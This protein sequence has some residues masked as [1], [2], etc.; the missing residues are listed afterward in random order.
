MM[1]IIDS[2]ILFSALIK[3]S[4]TRKLILEYDGVFQFPEFIFEEME[5]HKDELL[6]KSGLDEKSFNELLQLI[7]KKVMIVPNDVLHP[8]KE[9]AL[10]IVR[11]IDPDDAIFIA[12]ALAY[13]D[14]IIWSDDKKL[15]N[16]AKI[17]VI[18]TQKII[19]IL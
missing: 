16:Q 19:D 8:Y 5:K 12:C 2:N 17:K 13:P 11:Q 14:S 18:N 1:I 4:V 3:D 10:E 7:L 15:K 9:E 6:N